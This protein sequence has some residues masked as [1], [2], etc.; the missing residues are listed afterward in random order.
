MAFRVGLNWGDVI[1][2]GDDIYGDGVNVAAQARRPGRGRRHLHLDDVYRQ[3]P[4]QARLEFEEMG[5]Q[6]VKTI[7]EPVHAWH[8]RIWARFG[9]VARPHRQASIAVLPFIN[10]SG[11]AEQEYFSDGITEDIITDLSKISGLF[12]I[13]RNSVSST[14]ARR[15]TCPRS[16]GI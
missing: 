5:A 15:S 8:V 4:R 11:D 16:A 12:V 6:S 2:E 1:I 10:M 7:D 13:A 9:T 3:G 14:R